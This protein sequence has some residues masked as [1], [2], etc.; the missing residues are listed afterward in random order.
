MTVRA[1]HLVE[2]AALRTAAAV[3]NL[4]PYRL[5][6]S[7]AHPVALAAF[8]VCRF[9]TEEARRRIR[10][11]FGDGFFSPEDV[12]A[13]AR[14]SWL[15]VFYGAVEMMLAG[16]MSRRWI[17]AVLD[18]NEGLLRLK[19]HAD[20]GRGAI[21]ACP[22]MGNWELAAV[23]CH[24]YEIPIFTIAAR[25]KNPFVDRYLNSLRRKPGIV[26]VARGAGTMKDVLRHLREGRFLAILPDV[27]MRSGG[28]PVPFLGGQAAIGKGMGLFARHAQ[29]PVFPC[30]CLRTGRGRHRLEAG[31][32][33]WPDN[34]LGK[35]D[36]VRRLTE[37]VLAG[38][39]KAIRIDPGQWFWFNKRWVL[40]PIE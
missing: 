30:L 31:E 2:Y 20:T 37:T 3:V 6:L 23:A 16:R 22:H 26:T 12:T 32:P 1:S 18:G 39:E 9:R 10:S 25:Q 24:R 19:A 14:Q 11:V 13:I 36:D 7:F 17:D 4:M 8:N 40:D 28:L 35:E 33:L 38:V 5:A 21:I 34:S 27:R 15:N 29:V